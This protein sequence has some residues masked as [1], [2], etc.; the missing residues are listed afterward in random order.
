MRER[1]QIVQLCDR[2]G[3]DDNTAHYTVATS[4]PDEIAKL[5]QHGE[6]AGFVVKIRN[7]DTFSATWRF[8]EQL[9]CP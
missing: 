1:I 5:K 8:L 3:P 2:Y 9:R 6:Q 4:N 7:A